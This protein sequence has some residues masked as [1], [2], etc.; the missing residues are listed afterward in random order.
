MKKVTLLLL[1]IFTLFGL[2]Y[3]Q[4]KNTE[5]EK[6]ESP[7]GAYHALN[8]LAQAKTYPHEQLPAR[9]HFAA[10]EKLKKQ[11]NTGSKTAEP[12]ESLGPH[13]RGGRM[14][15]IT[16]NP[17]N[18]NTVYAG[19]A[20]GGLWRSY[21]AGIGIDAWEQVA[22]EFPV[23]GVSTIAIDHSDTMTM[24]IGTGEVYNF[25]AA[26][27]GAAYRNTRGS[28]GMGI[29]KSTDAGNTWTRSLDWAYNQQRGIWAI[30]IHPTNPNILYAATTEGVFKST[31]A[32]DSWQQIHDVVMATDL[33]INQE[34]PD[35]LV[36][37]CGNF[38]SP[39]FGV[40]KSTDAGDN[41]RQITYW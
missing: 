20:S 8:F 12:W 40:Y 24:Y 27:T 11:Q 29:L 9:S 39:G 4:N 18:P 41:W 32:G 3:F 1:A 5:T 21:T 25:E 28:Y 19:S 35:E 14:L 30:K 2:F 31:N 16:F 36:V 33:L 37:G 15:G 22:I 34:N 6:I 23:L 17:Q 10:W 7:S 38:A 26:G 13:N